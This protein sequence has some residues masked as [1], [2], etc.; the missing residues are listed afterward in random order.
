M[1]LLLYKNNNNKNNK[2]FLNFIIIQE[3]IPAS[4][5]DTNLQNQTTI[6]KNLKVGK[7]ITMLFGLFP[8]PGPHPGAVLHRIITSEFNKNS[9]SSC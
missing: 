5:T 4:K 7:N 8:N 6:N 9:N 1:I 2:V 3:W